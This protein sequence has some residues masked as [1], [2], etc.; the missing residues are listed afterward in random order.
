MEYVL[1]FTPP[2]PHPG[3][4]PIHTA[5]SHR[6]PHYYSTLSLSLPQAK[7]LAPE[8]PEASRGGLISCHVL[9]CLVVSGRGTAARRTASPV[10][11]SL[12]S[13]SRLF[14]VFDLHAKHL[15]AEPPE[16]NRGWRRC[17]EISIRHPK[18]SA[19]LWTLPGTNS[20]PETNR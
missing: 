20:Q 14:R 12:S 8:P 9:S 16:A 6:L 5:H 1:T 17:W 15:C 13:S 7:S 10:V 18:K 11:V 3:E 2:L 4:E 19:T